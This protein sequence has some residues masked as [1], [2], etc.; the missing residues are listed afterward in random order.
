VIHLLE[1]YRRFEREFEKKHPEIAGKLTKEERAAR[2]GVWYEFITNAPLESSDDHVY[3]TGNTL[4][5]YPAE[6]NNS[7][8]PNPE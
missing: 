3:L 5:K 7:N 4:S 1:L 8:N 2:F 6:N